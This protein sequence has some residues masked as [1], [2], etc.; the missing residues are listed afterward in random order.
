MPKLPRDISGA[1]LIKKLEKAGYIT[2]RQTGSHVRLQKDSHQITIPKHQILKIGTL[3]AI[4]MDIASNM[5]KTK[6]EIINLIF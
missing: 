3:N 1:E 2:V 6:F 5:H 4:L